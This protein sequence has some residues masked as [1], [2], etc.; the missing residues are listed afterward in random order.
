MINFDNIIIDI[1]EEDVKRILKENKRSKTYYG[2]DMT[3]EADK[4]IS[5]KNKSNKDD[6]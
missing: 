5:L 3:S 2:I 6:E 4:T 1:K